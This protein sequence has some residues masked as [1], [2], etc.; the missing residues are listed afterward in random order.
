MS[1]QRTVEIQCP[2]CGAQQQVQLYEVIN[3][4][5]EPALKEALMHNQLNRVV[6][7]SCD[8]DYRVDLPLLYTDATQEMM[9]HWVPESAQASREQIL[10]EFDEAIE[11]MNAEASEELSSC[12]PSDW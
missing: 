5:Q 8:L 11:R 1:I 2:G 12:P 3:V 6:C 10:E 4:Q 9:I 7:E